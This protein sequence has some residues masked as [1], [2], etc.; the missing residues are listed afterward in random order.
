MKIAKQIEWQPEKL[1][2]IIATVLYFFLAFSIGK[3]ASILYTQ[4]DL[5]SAGAA[6][7]VN[8][9][10]LA[11]EMLF[12]P[13]F[14]FVLPKTQ[15]DITCGFSM[16][17][18]AAML[19]IAIV[20]P[21]KNYRKGREHGSAHWGNAQDIKPFLDPDFSRNVILTQTERIMLNGRPKDPKYARNKNVVVIGGSGSG[22]TR[23]FIKPNLLQMHSSYVITDPNGSLQ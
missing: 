20:K 7:I 21:K 10:T 8:S 22:K 18:L 1:L 19:Y 2:K 9:M 13:L 6:G 15:Q 14:W 16:V 17:L 11:L 23:F 4:N 5:V 3:T 12:S